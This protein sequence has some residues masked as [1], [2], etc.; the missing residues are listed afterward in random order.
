MCLTRGECA[1]FI[2]CYRALISLLALMNIAWDSIDDKRVYK[3]T[4]CNM[5]DF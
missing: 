5:K 2:D 3:M 1:D 4:L